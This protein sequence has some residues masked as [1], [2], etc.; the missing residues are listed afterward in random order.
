MPVVAF[1]EDIAASGGYWL[2]IA[3]DEIY[4]NPSSIVGSIGV[5]TATFGFQDAINKLGGFQHQRQSLT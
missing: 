1:A 5:I 4:V 2:S 3:A